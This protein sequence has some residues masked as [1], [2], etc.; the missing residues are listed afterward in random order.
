V[1]FCS[2]LHYNGIIPTHSAPSGSGLSGSGEQNGSV[3]LGVNVMM[4]Q[5]TRDALRSSNSNNDSGN[6]NN[7]SSNSSSSNNN[8]NNSIG[9]NTR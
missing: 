1:L 8:N 7:N 6:N 4:T 3:S 9:G 2:R 5:T